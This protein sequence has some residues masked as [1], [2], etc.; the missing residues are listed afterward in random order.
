M[1]AK[2][3][4]EGLEDRLTPA[5]DMTIAT[6]ANANVTVATVGNQT[7][8][9]AN[10]TAAV[11]SVEF[12]AAQFAAGNDVTI[13]NGAG[14]ATPV[15][16]GAIN[17]TSPLDLAGSTP[18]GLGRTLTIQ[19][20]PSTTE[21]SISLGQGLGAFITGNQ[22]NNINLVVN[23]AGTPNYQGVPKIG[24]YGDTNSGINNLTANTIVTNAGVQTGVGH[25]EADSLITVL[26]NV[27]INSNLVVVGDGTGTDGISSANGSITVNTLLVGGVASG[28]VVFSNADNTLSAPVG[29]TINGNMASSAAG[30]NLELESG[31]INVSGTTGDPSGSVTFGVITITSSGSATFNGGVGLDAFVS[32]TS[33]DTY[34]LNLLGG[35]YFGGSGT[36]TEFDT[37]GVITLGNSVQDIFVF[38]SGVS[39]AVASPQVGG[40]PVVN[41]TMRTPG[42]LIELLDAALVND[43][44]LDTTN[45]GLVAAG[46]DITIDDT[47]G[48]AVTT[49]SL[50]TLSLNGGTGGIV[51]VNATLTG[52]LAVTIQNSASTEFNAP[53][54]LS[55]LTI[56]N[57]QSTVTFQAPGTAA[58]A[59]AA[60]VSGMVLGGLTMQ[61]GRAFQVVFANP[62]AATNI[63]AYSITGSPTGSETLSFAG[64][65]P[66]VIQQSSSG[67]NYTGRV[68]VVGGAL[69]VNGN[70]STVNFDLSGGTTGGTGSVLSLNSIAPASSVIAPGGSGAVGTLTAATLN[71]NDSSTVSI[72]L[73]M[74][75]GDR[76]VTNNQPVLNGARLTGTV[77]F[78][79]MK[80]GTTYTIVTN[81]SNQPVMG[82]FAGLPEGGT[83]QIGQQ[84]FSISYLAGDGNDISLTAVTGSNT[85]IG[86]TPNARFVSYL[87][88]TLLGRQVD[89][90]GMQVYTSALS[91]GVSRNAVA[92]SIYNSVEQRTNQV[93]GYYQ[94]FLGRSGT[95]AQVSQF[96]ASLRNGSS[97]NSVIATFLLSSE[98]QRSNPPI[99]PF[100][101]AL[102]Q[103]L[104]GRNADARGLAIN[105]NALRTG[106]TRQAMVLSFL[107]G[108]EYIQ[109]QVR[110]QFLSQLGN[111]PNSSSLSFWGAQMRKYGY[112]SM[113]VGLAS[114]NQA[115]TRAQGNSV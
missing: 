17:W 101:R 58:T 52:S 51:E 14:A 48:H 108:S 27:T 112:G 105:S 96:V 109:K 26:G 8:V 102:Y 16:V 13:S 42:E 95:Q 74:S 38:E 72:D 36:E 1:A 6:G 9:T 4:L 40:A 80:T 115:F 83:T 98:F 71:L 53:V 85:P 20:N 73:T 7:T 78:N 103:N 11:V 100:V 91:R 94:Q 46:G 65:G 86:N 111:A 79:T 28:Q 23:A 99:V 10:A 12:L 77:N 90:T 107:N 66:V 43:V 82:I 45:G 18:S 61:S 110:A 39:L 60:A 33:G 63:P 93:Q 21:G 70:Y 57:T 113:V 67:A 92:A 54:N 5:F 41:A 69:T 15:E 55:N 35:G 3:G 25:V 104:L 88:L 49:T 87:Y 34:D 44:I 31:V 81:N 84:V 76:L 32:G 89:P 24:L 114:S 30:N 97:E 47:V 62:S 64:P 37:L 59:V 29:I 56:N 22:Q 68:S 75:G 19:Q 2:L 106:V 50:A